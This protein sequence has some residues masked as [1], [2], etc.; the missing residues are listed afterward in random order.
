[1]GQLNLVLLG[2]QGA[3]KGTQSER[4]C[5]L[6]GLIH[7]STGDILRGAIAAGTPLGREV[8]SILDAGALV[9]D[10]LVNQLVRDRFAEPDALRGG[11]LDGFPRTTGQAEA[12]EE[13]LGSNGIRLVISVELPDDLVMSRLSSRRVCQECGA[14]YVESDVAA[15]SGT[16]EVCGGDV[17]QRS[18]DQPE[19]I[20]KRLEAF[21][22]DTAPLVDF[23]QQRGLLEVVNGNQSPDDVFA[24][25][26]AVLTRRG[27]A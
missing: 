22:R 24:D 21:E 25:I 2:K 6:F 15:I 4:L 26:R 7:I 23:Y 3:G 17:V 27:V 12:L 14:T 8:K 19:A 5:E 1:M 13:F 11:V 18:D 20:R 16:C 9:S 10:E